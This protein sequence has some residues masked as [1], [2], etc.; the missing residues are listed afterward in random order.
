M[1]EHTCHL[2]MQ[3]VEE[4]GSGVC[5]GS[6]LAIESSRASLGYKRLSLKV[7]KYKT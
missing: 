1:L 4:G 2:S 6:S 3:Q 5:S 7:L